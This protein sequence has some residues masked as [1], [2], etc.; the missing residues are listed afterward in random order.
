M[1]NIITIKDQFRAKGMTK[2]HQVRPKADMTPLISIAMCTYNGER[3]LEQQLQSIVDQHYRNLEIIIVD[4]R[5]S[6]GTLAI[7]QRF[8]EQD[9]RIRVLQN[10]HNLGFI[11]NFERALGECRGEYIALADQDDVWLP[12]KIETLLS[13]IGDN[14]LIYSRVKLI[15]SNG[16]QIAGTFPRVRRIEGECPLSFIFENCV[17]GHAC[18]LKRDLL[19]RALPIPEGVF[20]HD[21]WLAIIAAGSGQL[22]ASQKLLSLYRS[23]GSNTLL[24]KRQ[25]HGEK[26]EKNSQKL[27]QTIFL[28]E[29]ILE[30][31]L[32][33]KDEETKLRH[34]IPLLAMN[35]R[36]LF[37]WR[38][39]YFLIRNEETFLK[40]FKKRKSAIAKICRGARYYH[41]HDTLRTLC[42]H[43]TP[44]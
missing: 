19:E 25:R 32:L 11:R 36:C 21:H 6:D 22:K 16:E 24:R 18:L 1:H 38:L 29:S 26:Q 13:E 37:N 35:S 3:F 34:L 43:S 2:E 9:S 39:A 28:A 30:R 17:T 14:L 44:A 31:H 23:H 7:L 15:D 41:L 33:S 20:A 27:H 40:P 42:P 4:D 10:P 8:Q 5:S 12:E